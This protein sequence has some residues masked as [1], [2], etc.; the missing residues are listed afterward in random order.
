MAEQEQVEKTDEEME[1]DADSEEEE[2]EVEEKELENREIVRDKINKLGMQ[3][4]IISL[5][6][7]GYDLKEIARFI[8]QETGVQVSHVAVWRWLKAFNKGKKKL[9]KDSQMLQKMQIRREI[10]LI[11]DLVKTKIKLQKYLNSAFEKE[12]KHIPAAVNALTKQL[13]LI[14]KL[15]GELRVHHETKN[16]S[17]DVKEIGPTIAETLKSYQ[18][19]GKLYCKRCRSR[20]ISF[21]MNN[22]S[23]YEE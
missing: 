4:T 20:D 8:T 15:L 6:S 5:R 7:K 18:K 9:L 2:E 21:D 3:E 22:S 23:V 1:E 19:A 16:I 12:E 11:D 10:D 14:A 13:E 17:I